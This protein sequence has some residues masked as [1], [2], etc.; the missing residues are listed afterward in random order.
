MIATM[1]GHEITCWVG[2]NWKV[3]YLLTKHK[4]PENNY[5]YAWNYNIATFCTKIL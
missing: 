4:S 3:S 2:Y 5:I 1:S